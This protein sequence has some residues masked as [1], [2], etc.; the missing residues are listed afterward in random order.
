MFVKD[1]EMPPAVISTGQ[2]PPGRFLHSSV[3][4]GDYVYVFGGLV[5]DADNP[6]M[7]VPS[8]DLL[9]FH[10]VSQVWESLPCT[11]TSTTRYV[12]TPYSLVAWVD[13]APWFQAA[14]R[15]QFSVR[16]QKCEIRR[17]NTRIRNM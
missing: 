17:T 14:S 2:C 9:R 7:F 6:T 11:T 10:L 15:H 5:P 4:Y 3:T 1:F 13:S 16:H 12:H 8:N